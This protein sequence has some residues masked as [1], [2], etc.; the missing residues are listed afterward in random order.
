MSTVNLMFLQLSTA[1]KEIGYK[2]APEFLD[3][4]I[5]LTFPIIAAIAGAILI[6]KAR[7][8]TFI[9]ALVIGYLFL[10]LIALLGCM[11]GI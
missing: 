1:Q 8:K 9:L 2:L 5:L 11:G 4:P 3:Y 6:K 7:A 10:Y